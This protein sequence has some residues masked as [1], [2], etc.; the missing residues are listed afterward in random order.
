MEIDKSKYDIRFYVCNPQRIVLF[1][2]IN[3]DLFPNIKAK[4]L[5][6]LTNEKINPNGSILLYIKPPGEITIDTVDTMQVGGIAIVNPSESGNIVSNIESESIESFNKL[7]Q[8][9]II[10]F[11]KSNLWIK[12]NHGWIKEIFEFLINM[13]FTEPITILHDIYIQYKRPVSKQVVFQKLNVMIEAIHTKK[14]N[15]KVKLSKNMID[16]FSTYVQ[17]PFEVAGKIAIREYN[18]DNVGILAFDKF[19]LIEGDKTNFVVPLPENAPLS[20]HTHPDICYRE[21]GCFLGWPSGQDMKVIP[22]KYLLNDDILAHFV[23]SAE[24]IWIMHLN[25]DFQRILYQLKK[26]QAN[27]C[28]NI[29]LE[30]IGNKF[31]SLETGRRFETINPMERHSI[32]SKYLELVNSYTISNLAQDVPELLNVCRVDIHS[33]GLIYNINLIKWKILSETEIYLDFDYYPDPDGG[34]PPYIPTDSLM[35]CIL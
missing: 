4:I 24:G 9:I 23:I 27:E 5:P 15:L 2:S 11:D 26:N 30:A 7:L 12:I 20:F 6:L 32:K 22:Q 13:G 1:N 10:V 3:V 18:D 31:T 19:N 34:L 14:V 8:T 17:R 21:F 25:Y 33:D 28:G 29:L 16:L 35:K